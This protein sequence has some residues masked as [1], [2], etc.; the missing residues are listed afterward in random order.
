MHD[1]P[2]TLLLLPEAS[3]RYIGTRLLQDIKVF[4]FQV[5]FGYDVEVAHIL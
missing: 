1:G 3:Y 2:H 5:L 4:I